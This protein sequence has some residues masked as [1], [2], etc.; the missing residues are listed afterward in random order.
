MSAL[1]A[2]VYDSL[3]ATSAKAYADIG[4]LYVTPTPP[5]WQ[6]LQFYGGNPLCLEGSSPS[7]FVLTS[8]LIADDC[9]VTTSAYLFIEPTA[10]VMAL[11]LVNDSVASICETST[12]CSGSLTPAAALAAAVP[13]DEQLVMGAASAV[14]LLNVSLMQFALDAT[15]WRLLL[16]PLLD[17]SSFAFYGWVILFEW[18]RGE[19]EVISF[20]G[21][22]GTLVLISDIYDTR[23]RTPSSAGLQRS[24]IGVSYMLVYAN[25]LLAS[26][27]MIA[28]LAATLTRDMV[29]VTNVLAFS[30]V[31]GS[32]WLGRPLLLLRGATA[33][34]LLSSS[35]TVV[36]R[37]FNVFAQLT[38]D[39]RPLFMTLLFAWEA[40]W[41]GYA[42]HELLLPCSVA[43]V[44]T[45]GML[46]TGL[47]W[48]CMV[49]VDVTWPVLATA[50]V[51]RSCSGDYSAVVCDSIVVELGNFHRILLLGSLACGFVLCFS[52]LQPYLKTTRHPPVLWRDARLSMVGHAFLAPQLDLV[53][54]LSSGL[55]PL[56]NQSVLDLKLW[57]LLNTSP[58][59]TLPSSP[60]AARTS[61]SPKP[62]W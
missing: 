28:L 37:P 59:V 22:N 33:I 54:R 17:S 4:A 48:L 60:A 11:A 25:L 7:S 43:N 62:S 30:R 35:S 39:A 56:S 34:V 27:T 23:L 57:R 50:T 6:G 46:A 8:F 42:L 9:S 1:S 45:I 41:V 31:A 53:A 32:T 2:A 24:S 18:V 10:M 26:I 21:D 51:S 3:N 40:T 19:R 49:L 61:D 58:T 5:K 38:L 47:G 36:K 14:A 12:W 20:Q 16:Q 52:L 29:V 55:I 44:R 15:T 13:L